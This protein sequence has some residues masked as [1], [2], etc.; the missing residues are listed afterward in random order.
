M[1]ALRVSHQ[2]EA[3][4]RLTASTETP[5]PTT[6]TDDDTDVK[7]H[8]NRLMALALLDSPERLWDALRHTSDDSVRSF[9]IDRLAPIDMDPRVLVGRLQ[10]ETD[11]GVR[12]GLYLSLGG[13]RPADHG[14]VLI[15][16]LA[17][18]LDLMSRYQT[19]LDPGEHSA[20]QWLL[21]RWNVEI[22]QVS[23]GTEADISMFAGVDRKRWY[24]T[25]QGHSLAVLGPAAFAMGSPEHEPGRDAD[26]E[27]LHDRRIDRV[28]AIGMHEVTFA[29]Y[30]RFRP[31]PRD[32]MQ[33]CRQPDCPVNWVMWSEAAAYCNWLSEQKG[34]GPPQFCYRQISAKPLLLEPVDGYLSLAGYRLPTEAEWEYACRGGTT[35]A[36][37][38]GQSDR[39]L[40]EFAWCPRNSPAGKKHAVG[41]K[42]PNDFGLFDVYG[43]A[44]EWCNDFLDKYPQGGSHP[45]LGG[46]GPLGSAGPDPPRVLRG[47]AAGDLPPARSAARDGAP[48]KNL[49]LA[50]TGF[51]LARTL[52]GTD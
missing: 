48:Y 1:R 19:C 28:F 17:Q 37:F 26:F 33:D 40:T 34:I 4:R 12:R 29:Q 27:T 8:A 50:A 24:V 5:P 51:R 31:R 47:Q 23:A 3:I 22:P 41:L 44:L 52:K 10:R 2:E 39:L 49:G 11:V 42:K 36:R 30:E 20:I 32:D 13:Y 43:N 18:T 14:R 7:R 16:E 46:P 21:R 35:T 15:D 25:S 6:P 38:F 9:L 45:D